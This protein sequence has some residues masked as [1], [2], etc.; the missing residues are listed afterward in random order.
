MARRWSNWARRHLVEVAHGV[1]RVE[2]ADLAGLDHPMGWAQSWGACHVCASGAMPP[3]MSAPEAGSRIARLPFL[4]QRLISSSAAPSDA[5][6]SFLLLRFGLRNQAGR[7]RQLLRLWSQTGEERQLRA[8]EET[9]MEPAEDV[10]HQA[11]GVADLRV[12][13]P[14]GGFEA[15]V[16]ELLAH[17]LQRHSVLQA[18]EIEVAKESMSPETVDP[19]WPS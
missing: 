13:R 17:H 3:E 8:G 18:M 6:S 16:G 4:V 2:D 10:V 15:G 19:P 7:G 5:A 12:T 14:A 1:C 11:L 9:Q